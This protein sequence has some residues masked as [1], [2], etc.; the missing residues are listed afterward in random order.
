MQDKK[1]FR[2]SWEDYAQRCRQ[3]AIDIGVRAHAFTPKGLIAISRGGLIPATILSH[4]LGLPIVRVLHASSYNNGVRGDVEIYNVL[5]FLDGLSGIDVTGLLFVDDI[6]DTG[7]TLRAIQLLPGFEKAQMVAS[8]GK[9]TGVNKLQND[10]V[11]R[12]RDIHE[13]SVW[14]K[15]PWEV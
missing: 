6:V 8:V 12:P 9:V 10:L 11:V 7:N 2:Y 4:Q 3:L 13:D 5:N 14:I 1:I 15:F